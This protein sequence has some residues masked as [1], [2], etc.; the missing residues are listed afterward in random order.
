MQVNRK[1]REEVLA[2]R[3]MQ[4]V[5]NG[6]KYSVRVAYENTER[7]IPSRAL[8]RIELHGFF[9]V[10]WDTDTFDDMHTFTHHVLDSSYLHRMQRTVFA[11]HAPYNMHSLL[12]DQGYRR[13]SYMPYFEDAT[14]TSLPITFEV[15]S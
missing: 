9:F 14:D 13:R 10:N 2:G 7:N 8:A 5:G 4:R 6:E 15:H 1:C 3:Q 11:F 12:R